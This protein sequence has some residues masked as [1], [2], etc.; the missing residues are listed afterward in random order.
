MAIFGLGEIFGF[1]KDDMAKARGQTKKKPVPNDKLVDGYVARLVAVGDQRPMFEVVLAEI[2][3]DER[4]TALDIVNIAHR[5]NQGGKKPSSKATALASISKRFVEIV[6]F[7]AK[8]KIAEK[9][10]P[11]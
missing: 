7:H 6:R 8:N 2:K 1:P 3:A 4:L 11:W 10:R 9:A 5:Y